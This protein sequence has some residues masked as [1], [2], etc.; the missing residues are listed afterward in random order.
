MQEDTS[1]ESGS[2]EFVSIRDAT[3]P[4]EN[5]RFRGEDVREGALA[6]R[7]GERIGAGRQAFLAAAGCDRAEVGKRPVVGL[8]ATGSE[9]QD[10]G[11][12]N[13]LGPGQIIETNRGMLAALV[14]KAGGVPVVYPAVPDDMES[15][16]GKL[17]EAFSRCDLIITSG[18]VSVG[19]MDFVKKAFEEIGGALEFWKVAIRPG[20]PF[21]FGRI[22]R[23][24]LFGLPGNPV[25]ALVTFLLLARPA[26]LKWQGA[27]D[28][29]LPAHPARLAED[30][31]NTGT[32]RH[33]MRVLVGTDGQVRST[34]A[35]ASHLLSS[36]AASNALLDVPPQT[37]ISAGEIVQVLRWDF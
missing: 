33:F 5:V 3:R 10:P 14:Q 22:D 30:V 29:F 35:Q 9:L 11:A 31:G 6:A 20:R 4:W 12:G 21:V 2:P 28:I 19:E 8:L 24:L 17:A 16:R 18:G 26:I 1:V 37:S 15:T 13:E 32:R 23:K 25:S 27:R 34:G 36:V 7:E